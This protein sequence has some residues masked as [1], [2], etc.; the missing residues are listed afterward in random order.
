M[1]K[2]L[3][4]SQLKKIMLRSQLKRKFDNNKSEENSKKYRKQRNYCVKL[5]RKTKMEYFKNMDVNR[6]NDN[7]MFWRTVKTK[8]SNIL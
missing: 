1:T 5:V 2:S 8:F 7:K 3:R 6:L 4:G